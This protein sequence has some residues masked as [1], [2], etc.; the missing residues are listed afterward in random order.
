MSLPLNIDWQQIL[1]HLFNFVILFGVLYF[2]LYKPVKKF[3][4]DRVEY[5][6]KMDEDAKLN[7]EE[8]EKAKTEYKEKLEC[9][10]DE[11]LAQKKEA[12]KKIEQ[13]TNARLIEAQ[14]EAEQIIASARESID[15][16]REKMIKDAQNEISE[17]VVNATEKL[18]LKSTTE[19][20]YDMF[21]DVAKRGEEDESE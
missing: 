20:I 15:R 18:V 5:Y 4:D 7:L 21:F 2:L 16:E 13:S 19:E 17:M 12:Y 6:K 1:L 11:I 10:E 14:K 3:M 8:S 9:A